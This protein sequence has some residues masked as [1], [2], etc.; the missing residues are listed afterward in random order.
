[1]SDAYTITDNEYTTEDGYELCGPKCILCG[2]ILGYHY[3]T[4]EGKYFCIR[5][6]DA[7]ANCEGEHQ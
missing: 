6:M 3:Q 5:Y 4:A 2:R 7:A 1:M